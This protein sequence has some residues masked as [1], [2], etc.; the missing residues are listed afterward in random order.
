VFIDSKTGGQ[1]YAVL[2]KKEGKL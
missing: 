1:V 2:T